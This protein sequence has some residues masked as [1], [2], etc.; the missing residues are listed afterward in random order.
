M[1]EP[2]TDMLSWEF[3]LCPP[4]P[5]WGGLTQWTL[6]PPPGRGRHG[7][8]CQCGETGGQGPTE[9]PDYGEHCEQS[10]EELGHVGQLQAELARIGGCPLESPTPVPLWA[11]LGYPEAT[12]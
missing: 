12:W 2:W 10:L 6:L 8:V 3:P 11:C 4:W 7:A 9:V 1:M 5:R